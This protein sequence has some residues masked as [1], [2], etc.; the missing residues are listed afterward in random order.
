M[1]NISELGNGWVYF[2]CP[3]D[4][5]YEIRVRCEM[6]SSDEKG[7]PTI[8]NLPSNTRYSYNL[9]EYE[10]EVEIKTMYFID[11]DEYNAF[12][13]IIKKWNSQS[14]KMKVKRTDDSARAEISKLWFPD[15]DSDS[16]DGKYFWVNTINGSS[17]QEHY[18]VWFDN[19]D[20]GTTDPTP[21]FGGAAADGSVEVNPTT[22]DT[23]STIAAAIKTAIDADGT[24]NV[25]IS[26]TNEVLTFTNDN[27]GDV[28]DLDSGDDDMPTGFWGFTKQQG[29]P[30]VQ[31]DELSGHDYV[32]VMYEG[33]RSKEKIY[34]GES[35]FWQITKV[36]FTQSE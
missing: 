28:K 36:E 4:E 7:D 22:G 5:T 35:N 24:W 18:Y 17:V 20:S 10:R 11:Y 1:T 9:E 12:N 13:Q 19:D 6:Y 33:A 23:G 27:T 21:T 32:Y 34:R 16:Y 31:F 3:Y 2:Y 15:D 29:S 8:E 26:R 30:Y 25:T 14:F